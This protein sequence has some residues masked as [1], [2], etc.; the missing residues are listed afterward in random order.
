M[1]V[2]CLFDFA[3]CPSACMF[4]FCFLSLFVGLCYLFALVILFVV[5]A[6]C[7]FEVLIAF[8]IV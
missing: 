5:C 2:V 1:F 6:C 7:V 4:E 3:C 8:C